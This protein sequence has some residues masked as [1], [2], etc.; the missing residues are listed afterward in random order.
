MAQQP[1]RRRQL[2][3][4]YIAAINRGEFDELAQ[5]PGRMSR[6]L[7]IH[8]TWLAERFKVMPES[9]SIRVINASGA[10]TDNGWPGLITRGFQRLR[11]DNTGA[12]VATFEDRRE[13][14]NARIDHAIEHH[15]DRDQIRAA[16][17]ASHFI[18][19]NRGHHRSWASHHTPGIEFRTIRRLIDHARILD[20]SEPWPFQ[21]RPWVEG[22]IIRTDGTFEILGDRP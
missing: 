5:T 19:I 9:L 4:D 16:V 3:G 17:H 6:P 13:T 21:V 18:A 1:T 15:L 11:F 2:H 20:R 22:L 8:N 7:T 10:L 12:W 14:G